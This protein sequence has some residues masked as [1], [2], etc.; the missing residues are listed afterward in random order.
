MMKKMNGVNKRNVF[1]SEMNLSHL[2]LA[3]G[4]LVCCLSFLIVPLS[5]WFWFVMSGHHLNGRTTYDSNRDGMTACCCW[6]C[7]CACFSSKFTDPDKERPGLHPDSPTQCRGSTV[8]WSLW[9]ETSCLLF[10]SLLVWTCGVPTVGH[11]LSMLL[12]SV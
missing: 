3:A 4:L 11:I 8:V 2:K 9:V 6:V 1:F 5:A 12:F 7:W 10:F